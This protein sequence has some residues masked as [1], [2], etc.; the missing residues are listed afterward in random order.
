MVKV[1]N[2]FLINNLCNQICLKMKIQMNKLVNRIF[3]N[4][5]IS[6]INKIKIKFQKMIL[7]IKMK[8]LKTKGLAKI[9]MTTS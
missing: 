6:I 9:I 4:K 1:I 8:T 3:K 5:I 7:T 2:K